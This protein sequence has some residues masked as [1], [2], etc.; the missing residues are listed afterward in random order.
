VSA[1]F[2]GIT[3]QPPGGNAGRKAIRNILVTASTPR[4]TATNSAITVSR[5]SLSPRRISLLCGQTR[6][7]VAGRD[8]SL[9][10]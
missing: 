10:R 1:A 5:P 8:L 4:Q 7:Q 2:E 6:L 9:S 3:F